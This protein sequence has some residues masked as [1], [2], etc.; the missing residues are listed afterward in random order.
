MLMH[1]VQVAM[2]RKEKV[3]LLLFDIKGFFDHVKR[4]R[5]RLVMVNMGFPCEYCDWAHSFLTDRKVRL[6]FN[7]F[8]SDEMGQPVG[9]PQGSPVSPVLSAIYTAYL[10]MLPDKW[11]NSSLAMYVDDG[12]ILAWA[13]DWESVNRLLIER[14]QR[15]KVW[16]R[17][18]NLAIEPDKSEV[19]YFRTPRQRL[20]FPPN[21]IYLLNPL[22]NTSYTVQASDTVR[23]LGFFINHKLDWEP[24][25]MI[26]CNRARASLKALQVL[27]SS[28]CGLS[29]A[30]WRLVFNAVCLPVLTYGCQLW[31]NSPKTKSLMKKVQGVFNE[32]VKVISGAFCTAPR[33]PL[34]KFLQILPACH[35]IEKL[36]HTSALRLY[37]VPRESQLLS[38]LGHEWDP[39]VQTGADWVLPGLLPVPSRSGSGCSTQRPTALE[40]LG[41]RVPAEAP[42]TDVVAIAPWEVPDWGERLRFLGRIHPVQRGEWVDSL[43]GAV[44]PLTG[45]IIRVPGT[46][47]NKDRS[48]N[49]MVGACAAVLSQGG[50][51]GDQV[52]SWCVGTEMSQFDVDM[53]ALTCTAE[54][55]VSYFTTRA[56]LPSNIHIL[57][58]SL[59]ALQA[60]TNTHHLE[61][62]QAV[63]LFHKS[64]SFFFSLQDYQDTRVH[65]VWAPVHRNREQD[66]RAR[67]RALEACSVAPTSG[68]NCVQSAAYLKRMA[69][70][71][72]FREWAGE[73][74]A[75]R[76]LHDRNCKPSRFNRSY[77]S[78]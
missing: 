68:L 53:M 41:V 36:T 51:Q 2:H 5:L 74:E 38:R 22:E 72:A 18:A 66:T 17:M 1:D 59:A 54:W 50:D 10:L 6:S 78:T 26:M 42:R 61:S 34:H 71:K 3:G 23:Y 37:R 8:T 45:A 4:D 55:I 33:E 67:S 28:H 49:R 19:I 77:R 62:Q 73:W 15:C 47:S 76:I 16:L 46:I 40:A 48:D 20:D 57:S 31:V 30:N 70:L 32:G 29:M 60:I 69:C 14:Y 63:L 27:G 52:H 43:Y 7:N 11:N 65:L 13:E 64:L 75:E 12:R 39:S 35:F 21:C 9:T 25:V 58:N 44:T 56:V 24:H